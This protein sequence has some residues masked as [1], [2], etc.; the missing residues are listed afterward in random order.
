ME[1][2]PLRAFLADTLALWGVAGDVQQG[3]GPAVAEI[4][5]ANGALVWIEP[6]SDDAPFRWQVR[7]RAAGEAPGAPREVRPRACSSLVG[8]LAAMREALN[9]ERGSAV[10][11]VPAPAQT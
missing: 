4:C 10:R 7:W 3:R 8:V 2:A 11:I 5:T 9:V 1:Q 6:A